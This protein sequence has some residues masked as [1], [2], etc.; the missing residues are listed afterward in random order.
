MY[1]NQNFEDFLEELFHQ[2]LPD[3]IKKNLTTKDPE[4]ANRLKS[5]DE[6]F[7]VTSFPE[8]RQAI[9]NKYR[10]KR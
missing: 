9:I 8:K 2:I 10:L 5:L 4:I 1:F 3:M 6:R 7:G